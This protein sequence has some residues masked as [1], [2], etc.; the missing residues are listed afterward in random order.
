[1]GIALI[2][3]TLFGVLMVMLPRSQK[4]TPVAEAT[5]TPSEDPLFSGQKTGSGDD[6]LFTNDGGTPT[7]NGSSLTIAS[8]GICP[9][10]WGGQADSDQDELPDSVEATY[11]T[12]PNK[13]DTDGDGYKDGEEIK[14]GYDPERSGSVRLDSDG[15]GLLDNEECRWKTDPFNKD[16]D[17]DSFVDGQEVKNGYD[18]TVKGDGNGSDALP[19]KVAQQTN[20]ALRPDVNS[21]NYTEGLAGLILGDRPVSQAGQVQVTPT[22]IQQTLA[23]AELNTDLP[24][25]STDQLTLKQSN[26]P[27]DIKEYLDQINKISPQSLLDSATLTNA[28]L[29]AFNGNTSGIAAIRRD[30]QN[31]QTAL[32][33]VP[34]PA[35]AIPHQKQLIAITQYIDDHLGTIQTYGKSDPVRAYLAARELQEGLPPH[36]SELDRLRAELENLAKQ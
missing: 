34:T 31:Y 17:G 26:T 22:Q 20:N 5:P 9:E 25:I 14:N 11:K 4:N 3:I 35:S 1:L 7:D 27:A 10:Q 32:K 30:L 19:E 28:L 24:V 29:Q 18:P 8:K 23:N 21:S 12:D 2:S 16:T 33:A 36:I 13:A 6:Q 15:D